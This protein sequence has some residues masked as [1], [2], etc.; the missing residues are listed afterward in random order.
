ML[1]G[2]DFDYCC[3]SNLVRAVAPYHLDESDVHDVLNIFQVTGL[4]KD[5]RYFVKPSPGQAGR[6]LRV[7]RRDRPALRDLN[8]PSRG[9]VGPGVGRRGRPSTPSTPA[10]RWASKS[11]SPP[12][13][14]SRAGSRPLRATTGASTGSTRRSAWVAHVAHGGG[15][16]KNPLN[17]ATFCPSRSWAARLSCH[18]RSTPASQFCHG[19]CAGCRRTR[20]WS[21]AGI[22][23]ADAAGGR[24][25]CLLSRK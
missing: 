6:L 22:C 24:P 23:L 7:L 16:T 3:H 12:R 20:R 14:S 9:P 8:L 13:G 10:T 2:E 4:T 1:N 19:D 18:S 17:S 11:I 25:Q 15:P 21:W 5:D